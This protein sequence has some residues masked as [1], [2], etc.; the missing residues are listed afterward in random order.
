MMIAGDIRQSAAMPPAILHMGAI[1]DG[2]GF[3]GRGHARHRA[4]EFGYCALKVEIARSVNGMRAD[5]GMRVMWQ[6]GDEC[7]HIYCALRRWTY[8]AART[9]NMRGDGGDYAKR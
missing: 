2:W 6:R 3:C 4:H 9:G 1:R 8:G 5:M 7:M